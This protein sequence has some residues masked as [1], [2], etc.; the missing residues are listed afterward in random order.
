MQGLPPA[1]S[2]TR[3][4]IG[5]LSPG[6]DLAPLFHATALTTPPPPH[7]FRQLAGNSSFLD[8]VTETKQVFAYAL[9]DGATGKL[10]FVIM[11]R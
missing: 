3:M 1:V 4:L 8:V 9:A 6:V 5:M 11:W 10:A 2:C 7:P